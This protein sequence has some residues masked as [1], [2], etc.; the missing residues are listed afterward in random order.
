MS[1]YKVLKASDIRQ[2]WS[3]VV[4]KVYS[5]DIQAALYSSLRTHSKPCSK[6]NSTRMWVMPNMPFRTNRRATAATAG[7][8]TE[9]A[10]PGLSLG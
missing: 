7:A 8:L 9:R 1:R 4:N 3:E 2:H 5:N 6:P 10:A